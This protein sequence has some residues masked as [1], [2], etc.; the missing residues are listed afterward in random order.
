MNNC[1]ATVR[2][3]PREVTIAAFPLFWIAILFLSIYYHFVSLTLPLIFQTEPTT[4]FAERFG[5]IPTGTLRHAAVGLQLET[6]DDGTTRGNP[7]QRRISKTRRFPTRKRT[8]GIVITRTQDV[9]NV[10]ANVIINAKEFVQIGWSSGNSFT[11]G[12]KYGKYSSFHECHIFRLIKLVKKR[13][14]EVLKINLVVIAVIHKDRKG[15]FGLVGNRN[16][17]TDI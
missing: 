10:V 5:G 16:K 9:L 8:H 6:L 15:R 4:V 11:E 3:N 13:F 17:F 7:H 14:G 1:Q 2:E 12:A